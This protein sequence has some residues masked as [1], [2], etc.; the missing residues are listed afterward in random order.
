MPICIA[1]SKINNEGKKRLPVRQ[2]MMITTT[3]TTQNNNYHDHNIP[4]WSPRHPPP[5]RMPRII[6]RSSV[7]LQDN[8]MNENNNNYNNNDHDDDDTTNV[9]VEKTYLKYFSRRPK[10]LYNNNYDD[11]DCAGHDEMYYG[12]EHLQSL[13]DQSRELINTFIE[14]QEKYF[15]VE[16]EDLEYDDTNKEE[17]TATP[18]E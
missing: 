17:E 12:D 1:I 14:T 9:D 13:I 4:R 6:N 15:D 2:S 11:D 7:L 10:N 3:T 8:N 18:E 16:V 5:E